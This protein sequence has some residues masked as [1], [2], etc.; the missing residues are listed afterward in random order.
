MKKKL[1]EYQ[2][3]DG[4]LVCVEV[5]ASAD[6]SL[7]RISRSGESIPEKVQASFN[8]T[9]TRLRPVADSVLQALQGLNIP[10]EIGLEFG[11]KFNAKA[12]VII[13]SVDSEATFKVSLKWS[14]KT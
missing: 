4:G 5:E 1:I 3:D 10:T 6:E 9:I 11:V 8:E 13:A 7:Q 14:N 12:G 2:L